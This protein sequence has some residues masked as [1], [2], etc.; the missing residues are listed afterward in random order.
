[1]TTYSYPSLTAIFTVSTLAQSNA[2]STE[3]SSWV[4]SGPISLTDCYTWYASA[5]VLLI[6]KFHILLLLQQPHK[7]NVSSPPRWPGYET[8]SCHKSSCLPWLWPRTFKCTSDIP[9]HLFLV[10]HPDPQCCHFSMCLHSL[11]WLLMLC[12]V[13]LLAASLIWSLHTPGDSLSLRPESVKN[14]AC[15]LLWPL[16]WPNLTGHLNRI[17]NNHDETNLSHHCIKVHTSSGTCL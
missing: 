8:S 1:M 15:P 13:N 11:F 17:K 3:H 7:Q 12:W 2:L 6:S 5:T 9:S 4:T 14:Y 10:L 16:L